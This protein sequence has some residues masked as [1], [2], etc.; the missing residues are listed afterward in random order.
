MVDT[1]K[2]L[3]GLQMRHYESVCQYLKEALEELDVKKV[4]TPT[5]SP[6]ATSWAD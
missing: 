1:H 2:H 4:R 3:K 6:P 5:V